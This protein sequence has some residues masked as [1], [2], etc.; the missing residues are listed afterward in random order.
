MKLKGQQKAYK[1]AMNT[2][3]IKQNNVQLQLIHCRQSLT[4]INCVRVINVPSMPNELSHGYYFRG[5]K[6]GHWSSQVI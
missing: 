6:S 4:C 1:I 5:H 2:D 3:T